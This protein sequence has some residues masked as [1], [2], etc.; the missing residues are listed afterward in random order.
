[1]GL[2]RYL[3]RKMETTKSQNGLKM[4]SKL[5]IICNFVIISSKWIENGK[6]KMG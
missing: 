4:V 2:K 6:P 1:M 5:Q 3:N